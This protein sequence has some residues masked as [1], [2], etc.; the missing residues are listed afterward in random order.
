MRGNARGEESRVIP[1]APAPRCRAVSSD[2]CTN[3]RADESRSHSLASASTQEDVEMPQ[4]RR[5]TGE[6]ICKFCERAIV[7]PNQPKTAR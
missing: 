2:R 5:T 3:P 4:R 7:W 1:H 6:Q